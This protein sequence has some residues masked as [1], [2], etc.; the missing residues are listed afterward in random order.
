[1]RVTILGAAKSGLAAAELARRN[2][3]TVF[4]SDAKPLDK[5]AD[6]VA[7]LEAR[8]I[9]AEFGAHTDL[10]TKADLI[11]VS[12]GVPPTNP[13]RLEAARLG[14][15]VIGEL[16]YAS[17][18]IINPI[19]A[20]TGTNGKTTTTVLTAHILNEA[21]KPA[22]VAGNIG[23][24][25]SSLVGTVDPTTIIVAECSS[26]QLDTT[27]TFRPH[28]SML[29]N[30][31]P[32]HL[33]YHGSFQQYVDA[34]WKIAEYQ[35]SNDVVVL[36]ADD[37]HVA[38]APSV[39]R[40]MV[41]FFSLL[42]EVD[43]AFVRGGEIILRDQQHN[44][45]I[46]MSLRRLGLPGAHNV[47]NSMASALA[48]RAFEV[49][50]ENIRDSL[51]SFNGVEH[52]LENVRVYK[53][54][55]YVNDSKATNINAAWFALSSYDHPIVWIAGGRGD[56]NDYTTLDDLISENVKAIVCMGEDADAIFNHW[57]TTKR[58]VKVLTME[59]AVHAAA[60][61]ARAEDVVLF[62]PACKSFDMFANFEERGRVFK[63]SVNAL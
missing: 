7:F 25:L 38:N 63:A 62:S 49:R 60:D 10:A 42:K 52:R 43:G 24:P 27:S 12:P 31:T 45:E 17:R 58:C 48:A 37:A 50:N 34:K 23:T 41:R 4:V 22:V 40:G 30:I 21:G 20:I 16:E 6:A 53:N 32:D 33:S 39:L 15:E 29:L 36:N 56:N 5:A 8:D 11:V 59:E 14:I 18:L 26:Y 35:Q 28:V 54:V 13:V 9:P 2:G 44:E 19:V 3:E 46:L 51:A 61:L 55:R 1:M 47:A 57:C